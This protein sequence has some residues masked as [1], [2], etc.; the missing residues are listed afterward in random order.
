MAE[1]IT[2]A[3]PYAKAAFQHA[4][5]AGALEAWSGVL[6]GA[7]LAVAEPSLAPLLT[8]PRVDK[9]RIAEIVCAAG[10]GDKVAGAANFFQILAEN[11]RLGLVTEIAELFEELRREHESRAEI[12][13]RSATDLSSAQIELITQAMKRRL[14][15]DVAVVAEI[16]ADLIGGA[17]ITVDDQV[18]DGSIIGRLDQLRSRLQA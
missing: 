12:H 9:R 2:I 11:Q 16:D 15:R 6:Q 13:I 14:G 18:I 1:R 17:V 10:Q 8:H 3:R 4:R 5:E 7:S